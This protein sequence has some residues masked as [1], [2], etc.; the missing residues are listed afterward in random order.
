MYVEIMGISEFQDIKKDTATYQVKLNDGSN[1]YAQL[2]LS[3]DS[4]ESSFVDSH[5][6]FFGSLWCQEQV[7]CT[8]PFVLL[9]FCLCVHWTPCLLLNQPFHN[10]KIPLL[11]TGFITN[12]TDLRYI[13]ENGKSNIQR[14][15]TYDNLVN[16]TDP[17]K[18][19]ILYFLSLFFQ[20]KGSIKQKNSL[21]KQEEIL[22]MKTVRSA[23]HG[24]N[25]LF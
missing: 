17:R 6:S 19:M 3:H 9:L 7:P 13:H 24:E 16:K 25:K 10:S 18:S 4:L 5:A 23:T 21:A 12:E 22:K 14:K 2:C 11:K 1:C 8:C 15:M 20:W